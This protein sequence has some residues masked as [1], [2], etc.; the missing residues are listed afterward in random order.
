MT[1]SEL[2]QI[3]TLS[4]TRMKDILESYDQPTGAQTRALLR[5]QLVQFLDDNP[6]QKFVIWVE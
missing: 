2:A 6:S 5:M 3:D 1:K 4:I